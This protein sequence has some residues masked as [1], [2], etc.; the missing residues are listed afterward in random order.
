MPTSTTPNTDDMDAMQRAYAASP[1][2]PPPA[3]EPVESIQ[4]TNRQTVAER[5]QPSG[6]FAVTGGALGVVAAQGN[7]VVA[8]QPASGAIP[9]SKARAV[10]APTRKAIVVLAVAVAVLYLIRKV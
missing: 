8:T 9:P 4:R 3:P 2:S 10:T 5:M 6:P 7:T 1:W